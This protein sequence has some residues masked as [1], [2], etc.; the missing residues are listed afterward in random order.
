MRDARYAGRDRATP[1]V[2]GGREQELL[3]APLLALLRSL[4][5]VD[6]SICASNLPADP[7]HA[8]KPS[9]RWIRE[10][11]GRGR[12]KPADADAEPSS[13]GRFILVIGS[14]ALAALAGTLLNMQRRALCE[15]EG[16]PWVAFGAEAL[17]DDRCVL[18]L[19]HFLT[20]E[21]ILHVRSIQRQIPQLIEPPAGERF[22]NVELVGSAAREDSV[23]RDI[24][25]RIGNLT[26]IAPHSEEAALF[27]SVS[28]PWRRVY[29]PGNRLQN[30]HHDRYT[31]P[32]RVATVL[33]YL[34]D[35]GLSGGETLF[36]CVRPRGGAARAA[37]DDAIC[38]RLATRLAA[39]LEPILWPKGYADCW[40]PDIATRTSDMCVQAPPANGALRFSP[41]RGAALLFLSATSTDAR[42]ASM[43]A[44]WHGSCRV[45]SGEKV[46][47]QKFKE[48]APGGS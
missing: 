28:R 10:K 20:E 47:L 17:D 46:T 9:A 4:A 12:P 27:L 41:R 14:S 37:D 34:H 31:A 21:E 29:E 30:L 19:P 39:G 23:L 40:A 43:G 22:Q 32:A 33:M 1:R 25:W 44:T 15:Y 36:P 7:A 26:G 5:S 8:S 18:L 48:A 42:A 35:E 3:T 38:A 24:E 16:M 6:L 45:E 2:V 11:M 13:T